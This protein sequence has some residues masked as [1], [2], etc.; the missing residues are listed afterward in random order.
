[1]FSSAKV[2]IVTNASGDATVYLTHGINRNPNGFLVLLQYTPGTI[3][4][5]ADLTITGEDSGIPIITITD[6]GTSPVFWYP[7]ALLNAVADGAAS[8]NPSEFIPIE[9]E[10]IKV[11]VAQGGNGGQGLIKAVLINQPPY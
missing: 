7:R 1:M 3:A 6:A 10:R 8:D 2:D 4:T 9:N 5:G 11:V